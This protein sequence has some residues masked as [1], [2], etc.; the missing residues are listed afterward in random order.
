MK[1]EH[2]GLLLTGMFL[3]NIIGF[4]F[5]CFL[6]KDYNITIICFTLILAVFVLG[7]SANASDEDKTKQQQH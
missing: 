2:V 1:K 7:I 5:W 4:G 3:G 6:S